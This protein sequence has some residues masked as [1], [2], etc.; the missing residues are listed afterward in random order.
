MHCTQY[1]LIIIYNGIIVY[2]C[3]YRIAGN[4]RVDFNF[5]FFAR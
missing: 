5:A 1:R 3:T 4:F 2:I